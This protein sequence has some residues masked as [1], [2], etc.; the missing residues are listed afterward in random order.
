MEYIS[1]DT[2]VWIDYMA[3]DKLELPFRLPLKFLMNKDAIDDEL[4]SPVGLREK[5]L[6]LGL[7][8]TELT[9]NEFYYGLKIAKEH[10]KLS[11]YDC[12]A[13]A[14]AKQ[15]ELVLLTGDAALRKVALNEGVFSYWNYRFA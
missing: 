8:S 2:N 11:E 3:I 15:R 6:I 13:L 1:S 5:L 7:Q 14:I 10:P 9:E 4:L 12:S